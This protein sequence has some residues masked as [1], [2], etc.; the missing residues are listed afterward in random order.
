MKQ[1]VL[2]FLTLIVSVPL[3]ATEQEPERLVL[4]GKEYGMQYVPLFDLDTLTQWQIENR[5]GVGSGD[6]LMSTGLARGYVGYWSIQDDYLYLDSIQ[7]LV[8][9]TDDHAFIYRFYRYDDLHDLLPSHCHDGR[10]RAGWVT[11]DSVLVCDYRSE[12]LLYAH[13]GFSSRFSKEVFCS[14]RKGLL[15]VC[16]YNNHLFHE[17]VPFD[18]GQRSALAASFPYDQ[19]PELKGRGDLTILIRDIQVDENGRLADCRFNFGG[20]AL[21]GLENEEALKEWVFQWARDKMLSVD[22]QVYECDGIKSLGYWSQI[23]L[24]FGWKRR[25]P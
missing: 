3:L 8:D 14:F 24:R 23:D 12:R 10:I 11:R 13:M 1:I 7:V 4:N 2:F 18:S 9:I 22:W 6:Y 19:F 25:T 15:Y 21:K 5:I 16:C 20:L 17:G